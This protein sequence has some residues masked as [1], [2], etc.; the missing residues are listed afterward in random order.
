MDYFQ[1]ILLGVVEGITEYLPVSSTGHLILTQRL[2]GIDSS[3]INNAY[4]IAIQGGAILAVLAIYKHRF[5]QLLTGV[6]HSDRKGLKLLKNLLV[7]FLPAAVIGLLFDK[8][9]E[10]HLFGLAPVVVAWFVGGVVILSLPKNYH[11]KKGTIDNMTW[12]QS[13]VIGLIQCFAMWPGVSRSLATMLGG[14]WVGLSMAGAIEFSFLL[15]V[16]TLSAASIFKIWQHGSA[17]LANNDIGVLLSGFA[18]SFITAFMAVKWLV[19]Y[20]QSH[21][22]ILF[23]WWRIG[24]AI[25]VGIGLFLQIL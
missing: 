21:T 22:L 12:Q 5:L 18:V 19:H 7:A 9:I 4:I 2:L 13:L 23:A 14:M 16:I 10:E 20:L 3:A 25:I 24:L 15:G 8:K 17:L 1:S 11:I 6:F